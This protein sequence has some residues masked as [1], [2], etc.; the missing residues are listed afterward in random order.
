MIVR[1][2]LVVTLAT[3]ACCDGSRPIAVPCNNDHSC[4][5][6]GEPG[7]RCLFD[8]DTGA[9]CARPDT[10]CPSGYRWGSVSQPKIADQCLDPSLAP[11]DGGA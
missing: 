1:A 9:Y 4:M 7:W 2:V 8:G 10:S 11:V 5:H 6:P 3:A